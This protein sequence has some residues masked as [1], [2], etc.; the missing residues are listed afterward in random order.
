MRETPTKCKHH[1][2]HGAAVAHCCRSSFPLVSFS[3]VFCGVPLR[4]RHKNSA[5]LPHFS[6]AHANTVTSSFSFERRRAKKKTI[7]NKLELDYS[8]ERLL[9]RPPPP[10]PRVFVLRVRTRSVADVFHR[11]SA[12]GVRVFLRRQRIS[13]SFRRTCGRECE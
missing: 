9:I 4:K 1:P 3:F 5:F 8:P 6:E 11:V 2:R 12:T 10:T 7:L 13:S